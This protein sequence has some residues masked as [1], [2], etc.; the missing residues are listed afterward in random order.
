MRFAVFLLTLLMASSTTFCISLNFEESDS[1]DA[2]LDKLEGGGSTTWVISPSSGSHFGGDN[3]TLTGSDFSSFFPEPELWENFTID[4]SADVGQYSSIVADSNSELHI[5]YHDATNGHLKYASNTGGSWNYYPLDNAAGQYIGRFTS[6]DVDSNDKVHISYG[7]L[8]SWDLK[9]ATNVAG[10]WSRSTIDNGGSDG[11]AGMYSSLEIDSND[12]IHVS[13]WGRNSDLKHATKSASS[14]GTW[15]DYTVKWGSLTG[16]WTSIALDSNNKP[17][18]SYVS[19]TWDR[20]ELAHKSGSS[21]STWGDSIVDSGSSGE[22]DNGTSIAIDSNDAKHIVY[23]DDENGDLRYADYN[24][25]TNLWQNTV[26]DSS[27][28]VGK[29]PSI[30]IDSQDNLHVAYYDNGNQELEYAY[31]DGSS[32]NFRLWILQ[33]ACIHQLL[34]IQ[35]ITYTFHTMMIRIRT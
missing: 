18:I 4:S 26:L 20:L 10:S 14:G 1:L 12:V 7:N 30:A 21:T 34:S 32:W 2:K 33:E 5:A 15:S 23:Y 28:D 25:Q 35:T 22:I 19:E 6:I 27:G 11:Y 31:H 16:E 13:Y 17:W 9:Y 3:I 29:F 24:T 8:N